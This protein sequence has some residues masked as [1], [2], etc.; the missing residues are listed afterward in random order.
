MKKRIVALIGALTLTFAMSLNV[1]AAGSTN[2]SDV[3]AQANKQLEEV[4]DT[5]VTVAEDATSIVVKA[6]DISVTVPMSQTELNDIAT[7]AYQA[8]VTED[9]KV[10]GDIYVSNIIS[11]DEGVKAAV[12]LAKNLSV[13]TN[14]EKAETLAAIYLVK[15]GDAEKSTVAFNLDKLG[16]T[17]FDTSKEQIWAVNGDT[18]EKI[19]GV[20]ENGNVYFTASKFSPFTIVRVA[21]KPAQNPQPPYNPKWDPTSPEYEGNTAQT[22]AAAPVTIPVIALAPKTGDVATLVGIMAVIF[23]GGAATAVVMSKKRA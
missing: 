12:Q 3:A 10:T 6:G 16:A 1:F 9:D 21:F 5:S 4:A 8:K 15:D 23:L 22:T 19:V 13:T 18:G 7:K 20:I 17:N 11:I 14:V 2:A